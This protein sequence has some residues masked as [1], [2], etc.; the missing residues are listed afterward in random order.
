MGVNEENMKATMDAMVDRSRGGVSLADLGFTDV[1]LDAGFEDCGARKVGGRAAFHGP[2]GHVLV[3]KHKFPSGLGALVEYGHDKGLT[4]SWYGNAC[5]C[6]SENAY[7]DTTSP[8]IRQAIAGTVADTAAYKFDGLKLDSCSQF[9]NM[10]LWA[11]EINKTGRAVLLENCHQVWTKLY[12][13]RVDSCGSCTYVQ[14]A[15]AKS[16]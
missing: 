11:E 2:D 15:S 9:N 13:P 6:D 3:D 14:P 8:T 10:T 4:V 5:A 16:L 1:G 7:T 12:S